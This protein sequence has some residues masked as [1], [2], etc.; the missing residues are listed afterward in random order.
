M[1]RLFLVILTVLIL[2]F[3]KSMLFYFFKFDWQL[4]QTPFSAGY[5]LIDFCVWLAQ[6]IIGYLL[7]RHFWTKYRN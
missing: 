7:I 1:K 2:Y 3:L 5:L 6:F 4:F